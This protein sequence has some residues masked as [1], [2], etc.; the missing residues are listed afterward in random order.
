MEEEILSLFFV[1][2]EEE[3]EFWEFLVLEDKK[4]KDNIDFD[5]NVVF[6][7]FFFFVVG[8]LFF[9]YDIGVILGVVV[10]IVSLEYSG[11]DWYNLSLL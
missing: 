4:D 1:G 3:M 5:W 11:I 6:L 2:V 9:G 8:G 7:F 10:F